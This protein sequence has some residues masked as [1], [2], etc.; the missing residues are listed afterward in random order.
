MEERSN[1]IDLG[2]KKQSLNNIWKGIYI[3][4]GPY[5]KKSHTQKSLTEGS[6]MKG[7]LIEARVELRESVH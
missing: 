2:F 5:K 1:V 3:S 6:L 7:L 4:Q